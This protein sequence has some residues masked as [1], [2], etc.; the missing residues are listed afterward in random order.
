M[1]MYVCI[2]VYMCV[3]FLNYYY[4]YNIIFI[5]IFRQYGSLVN[6]SKHE[7]RMNN[8]STAFINLS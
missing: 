1:Y 7:L 2:C 3:F 4:C 8:T 6:I 5:V